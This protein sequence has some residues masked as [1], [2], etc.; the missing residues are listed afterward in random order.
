MALTTEQLT[1]LQTRLSALLLSKAQTTID[2]TQ[3]DQLWASLTSQQKTDLASA[4]VSRDASGLDTLIAAI[5]VNIKATTDQQAAAIIAANGCSL[6]V[7][8]I[9][10][11]G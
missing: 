9:A 1:V 6:D 5:T 10:L 2:S 11:I 3:L 8:Y 7:L 4:F